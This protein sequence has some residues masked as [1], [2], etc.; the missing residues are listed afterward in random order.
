M[1]RVLLLVEGPTEEAFA[2]RVLRPHLSS[3]G[4]HIEKPSLLRTKEPPAGSPYKGGVTTFGRLE[5]DVGRLLHDTNAVVTTLIDFYGLP[6]DFPK[7]DTINT[8]SKAA[9][10][11]SIL[12]DAFA[13]AIN[14]PRFRPFL[15][16]HEFEALVF[17]A[18]AVAAE[19]LSIPALAQN[20]AGQVV[21]CGGAEGVNNHPSTC[22]SRRLAATVEQL[23]QRRYSKVGDGPDIVAKAGLATV[24]AACPHFGE[25]LA[26]LENLG[27]E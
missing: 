11:V 7:I 26:W 13:Q 4:V 5:R 25:W 12:E 17:A 9:Q 27:S 8:V 15:T 3:Y 18:P 21:Q 16:L 22:P 6:D 24:R 10:Q 19:H 2:N 14:H 23:G 20:L 1:K